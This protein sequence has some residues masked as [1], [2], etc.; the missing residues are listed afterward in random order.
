[1]P[2]RTP[3]PAASAALPITGAAL[4]P[5]EVED[6]ALRARPVEL[7]DV[8]LAKVRASQ[9]ALAKAMA[10]GRAIYGVNTGF[11][12]YADTAIAPDKLGE[13]QRNLLRSHAAGVGEPLPTHTVRAMMLLQLASLV[14][15]HSAVRAEIPQTIAALLNA[16]TTP[17]V[18]EVGS[19]GASG[20]LAPLAHAALVL[21]GEGEALHDGKRIDGAKALKLAKLKPLE[22]GP[23]EALALINGTHLMAAQAALATPR[24][25]RLFDA[26][27]CAC[28]MSME[29]IRGSASFLDA[30]VHDARAQRG[31]Q[32]VAARLRTMLTGS[33]I[34][35][36]HALDDPRV[37]DPYSFRCAPQVL[38]GALDLIESCFTIFEREL[39]AVTD[40]P[41]VFDDAP[42]TVSAGNFHGA[43]LAM[44]LDALTIA[45]SHIANIAERRIY[46]MLEARDKFVMPTKKGKTPYAPHMTR[47]PGLQSGYMIV[48]Y[49]AAACCNEIAL[50]A[51][52]ASVINIPTSAGMEDINSFGPRAAAKARRAIDL[53]ERV[54]A[55][56]L[57]C[58]AEGMEYAHDE[59]LHSGEYV[60]RTHQVVRAVA[61][62]LDADRTPHPDVEALAGLIR[63]GR[64][65]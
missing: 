60:E 9:A 14:R 32:R 25:R 13:L 54:V 2:H 53:T 7:T 48:Q 19:V 36:S 45:L 11:G 15:G 26:A 62:R 3:Q 51:A 41:L 27:L 24:V 35:T 38:G 40:N 6:V 47:T 22:L 52:P 30:R 61:P 49:V 57:L 18:P 31:Q 44:H 21:I 16:N 10:G 64:F 12:S 23:K 1:M 5:W 50:L 37:Q 42:H 55:M 20:D 17:I 29:A 43:P 59:G 8:A 65:G 28:A 56:E 58:A 39:S 34:L 4:S 33:T 63:A 46:I